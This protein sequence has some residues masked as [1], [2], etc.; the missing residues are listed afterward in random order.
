[1]F[2]GSE[3]HILTVRHR[4]EESFHSKAHLLQLERLA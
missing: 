2:A 4:N 1:M 3:F